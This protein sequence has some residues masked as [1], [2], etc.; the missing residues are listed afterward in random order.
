MFLNFKNNLNK[1]YKNCYE[2]FKNVRS[3]LIVEFKFI[4]TK[5]FNHSFKFNC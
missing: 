4:M 2:K 1:L 5:S 3:F